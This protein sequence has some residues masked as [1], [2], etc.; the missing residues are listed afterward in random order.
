MLIVRLTVT[1]T[2]LIALSFLVTS[3]LAHNPAVIRDSEVGGQF[4][5]RVVELSD[6]DSEDNP[7][8]HDS[9]SASAYA[10]ETLQSE[11]IDAFASA[12]VWATQN[13]TFPNGN[14]GVPYGH[15]EYYARVTGG[16]RV[17][18]DCGYYAGQTHQGAPDFTL[19]PYPGEDLDDANAEAYSNIY[20]QISQSAT[21]DISI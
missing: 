18:Q 2:F 1:C 16:L 12:Y 6:E 4:P 21:C 3:S 19:N 15:W 17:E 8:E 7:S 20:N 11:G 5:S 14:I 13:L 10:R 9:I